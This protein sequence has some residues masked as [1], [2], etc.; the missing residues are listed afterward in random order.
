M[1]KNIKVEGAIPVIE[2]ILRESGKVSGLHWLT[3]P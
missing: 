3:E 1:F 2:E